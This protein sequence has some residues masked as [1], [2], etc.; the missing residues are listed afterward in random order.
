MISPENH[1]GGFVIRKRSPGDRIGYFSQRLQDL[2]D[3]SGD[4][5]LAG[6]SLA[7][8]MVGDEIQAEFEELQNIRG[9]A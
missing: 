6:I 1:A 2:A 7:L 9:T 4:M 3:A 8:R 5:E